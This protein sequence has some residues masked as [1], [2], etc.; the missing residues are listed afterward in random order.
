M[1]VASID[2]GAKGCMTIFNR[3]TYIDS[4]PYNNIITWFN[5]LKFYEPERIN[6][7]IEDVHSMP[8]QGVKSMFNFGRKKGEVEAMCYILNIKP[9]WIIPQQWKK[10]FNLINEPKNKSC[11]VANKL[12]PTIKCFGSRG[13]CLDGV[14]DSYL[15]GK[16]YIEKELN[17]I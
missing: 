13:G 11:E 16:Y 7:I 8:K 17:G 6:I 9:I 4:I 14:A 5:E 12:E 15:I 2:I 1:I 3:N 10:H